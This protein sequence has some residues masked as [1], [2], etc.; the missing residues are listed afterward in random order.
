M[1]SWLG[2]WILSFEDDFVAHGLCIYVVVYVE[3]SCDCGFPNG[4]K[5]FMKIRRKEKN[6]D[7]EIKWEC[8]MDFMVVFSDG[9]SNRNDDDDDDGW[10]F[11]LLHKISFE[12]Y[13]KGYHPFFLI[14]I[15]I[16]V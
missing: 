7:C 9:G 14:I 8:D 16:Y 1:W 2:I 10:S 15:A 11:R 6:V 3:Y 12:I 13:Q 5:A 4:Q